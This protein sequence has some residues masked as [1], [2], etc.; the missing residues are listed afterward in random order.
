VLDPG[1][2]LLGPCLERTPAAL[3]APLDVDPRRRACFIKLPR[4]RCWLA[5]R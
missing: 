5:V 3:H 2:H 1:E 4:A